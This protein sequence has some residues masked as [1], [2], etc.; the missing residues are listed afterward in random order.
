MYTCLAQDVH[1]QRPLPLPGISCGLAYLF[2]LLG[3]VKHQFNL[4]RVYTYKYVYTYSYIHIIQLYIYIQLL[5]PPWSTQH[6]TIAI[7]RIPNM[8]V[9]F[10][11][12]LYH[13]PQRNRCMVPVCELPFWFL[14]LAMH[15]MKQNILTEGICTP[16]LLDICFFDE[17]E[18][19]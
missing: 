1:V 12:E 14:N 18:V 7:K 13:K 11:C 19:T 2:F 6:G 15:N 10:A 9:S 16:L 17:V 8:H 3:V 5:T 4:Y